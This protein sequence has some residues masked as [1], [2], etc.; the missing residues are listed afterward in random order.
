MQSRGA[1]FAGRE[2][3]QVRTF[4]LPEPGPQD[5]ALQVVACGVCG[6]DLHQFY[7]RWPQPAVVPGHE[8]SAVITHVGSQVGGLH[9]GQVVAVEPITRCGA[10]RYCLTGRYLL[11]DQGGF[12]SV[13]SHGGFAEQMVVPAYCCFGLGGHLDPAWGA[14]AEPLSV[15][16]HAVR[17]ARLGGEHAVLVLGSGTIGLLTVAAAK[18]LGI[19]RVMVTAKYPHQAEVAQQLGA[20]EVLEA[21]R[22]LEAAEV[23]AVIETVGSAGGTFPAAL[24]LVRKLGTVILVGGW[25]APLTLDLGAV[26]HK[27]LTILGSPCYGQLGL[28]KDFEIAVELL[29]K[30]IVDVR[31]LVSRRLPLDKIQEA[32][33]TAADKAGG[34][35]KVLVEP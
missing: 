34:V 25:T 28:R 14:F 1:F 6:S 22:V 35:I 15:G 7:G 10:C 23:D 17:L 29:S 11:C 16:L 9:P 24:R 13:N 33:L 5:V 31:P 4:E 27:E 12:I 18:A 20:D 30:R 26:I 21:E 8:V 32:F 2:C 19:G 3:L